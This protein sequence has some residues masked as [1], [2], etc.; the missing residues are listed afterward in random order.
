MRMHRR[1]ATRS[2]KAFLPPSYLRVYRY[3][4]L[5]RYCWMCD[6]SYKQS[7]GDVHVGRKE[8]SLLFCRLV[9]SAGACKDSSCEPASTWCHGPR[10]SSM[11]Q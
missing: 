7:S 10:G 9:S 6:R 2:I 11:H 5:L 8:E 4:Q 3:L 1:I